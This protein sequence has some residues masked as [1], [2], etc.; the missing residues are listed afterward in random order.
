MLRSGCRWFR[1]LV[2]VGRSPCGMA[3]GATG[4]PGPRPAKSALDLLTTLLAGTDSAHRGGCRWPVPFS[5]LGQEQ[6]PYRLG[7]AARQPEPLRCPSRKTRLHGIPPMRSSGPR[8]GSLVEGVGYA[9]TD[10]ATATI[11]ATITA[12]ATTGAGPISAGPL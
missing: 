12:A 8:P 7:E 11:T 9:R 3:P 4:L 2:A 6:R 10:R 1:P 5:F